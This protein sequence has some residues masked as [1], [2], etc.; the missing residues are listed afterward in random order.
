MSPDGRWAYTL[1]SGE[2]NFV[3][4]LD[5]LEGEAALHRPPGRRPLGPAAASSTGST[6]HVGALATIDLRTF[7]PRRG[8][9]HGDAASDRDARA[10]GR[11]RRRRGSVGAGGARDRRSRR[12]VALLLSA[13]RPE[14]LEVTLTHHADKEKATL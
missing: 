14:P 10:A 6:L 5:T 3:H 11:A 9:G 13:R 12:G 7:E 1:Y 4:A 8:R 2:E